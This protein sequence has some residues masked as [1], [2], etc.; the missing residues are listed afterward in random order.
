M[1]RPKRSLFVL[2]VSKFFSKKIYLCFGQ[3]CLIEAFFLNCF[4]CYVA[5]DD[6]INFGLKGFIFHR[7]T[8]R[9]KNK[10]EFFLRKINWEKFFFFLN[11]L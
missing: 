8:K 10:R 4:N 9:V 11:G 7:E 2:G 5:L 1:I 3:E 6:L